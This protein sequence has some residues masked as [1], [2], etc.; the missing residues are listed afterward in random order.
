MTFQSV[1]QASQLVRTNRDVL[2]L[3]LEI[4]RGV[5]ERRHRLPYLATC[6]ATRSVSKS[7]VAD[8]SIDGSTEAAA[9]EGVA[10]VGDAGS[11]DGDGDPD[12]DRRKSHPHR[13]VSHHSAFAR[14]R[15]KGL[16]RSNPVDNP[17]IPPAVTH[18]PN[19][20][21]AEGECHKI[22]ELRFAELW[23]KAIFNRRS[24]WMALSL[25]LATFGLAIFF[26]SIDKDWLAAI[27][28]S[29]SV[30][31]ITTEFLR[32]TKEK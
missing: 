15:A 19:S 7:S 11:G 28:L 6:V 22:G 1:T 10:G 2:L 3:P 21:A 26:A 29:K 12:S 24:Q 14:E 27:A 32:G 23:A 31:I 5:I 30:A 8:A 9:N 13:P 25:T 17:K 18:T 20:E 16:P 4:A